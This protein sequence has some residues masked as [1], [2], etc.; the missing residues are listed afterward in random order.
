[1]P[2][3][4]R[5]DWLRLCLEMMREYVPGKLDSYDSHNKF[6]NIGDHLASVVLFAG[7]KYGDERKAEIDA[8]SQRMI[9]SLRQDFEFM[10]AQGKHLGLYSKDK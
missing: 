2:C 3:N 1:M 10:K 8:L 5:T 6:L 7:K 9:L 4:A